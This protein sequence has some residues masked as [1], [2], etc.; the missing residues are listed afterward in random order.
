MVDKS[1]KNT[2][3]VKVSLRNGYRKAIN[4][5]KKFR[6]LSHTIPNH[7]LNWNKE[8]KAKLETI[9]LQEIHTSGRERERRDSWK[10]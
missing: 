9:K 6:L 4:V 3:W 2:Y 10:S 8:L 1:I 7:Q 5:Q